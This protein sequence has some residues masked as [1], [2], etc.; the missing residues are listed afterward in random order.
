MVNLTRIYTR[1]GDDGTTRLGDFSRT[2]KNDPRLRRLR[3]HRRGQQRRSGW[4][5]ACGEP[6]ATR[7]GAPL[8]R[9]QNDL[10]DVGADLCTP[11]RRAYEYPPL[12][13]ERAW[14]DDLEADCDHYNERAREAA[15]VHPARRHARAR[16]TCTSRAPSSRRAERSAWAAVERYGDQPGTERRRRR[17]QPAD[18]EV[19]QPALR[20]AV[21]PRPGRE[22]GR[23]AATCCGSRAAGARRSPSGSRRARTEPDSGPT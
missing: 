7:C 1:T 21:H 20:P 2:S 9:V 4:R 10:F 6:A 15:L 16:R 5:V 23:S 17:R 19:P 12:R 18:G 22:P 11:L 3:R 14:V 8:Q 13:V